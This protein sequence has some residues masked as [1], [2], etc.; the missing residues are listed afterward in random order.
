[1]E[2]SRGQSNTL[3]KVRQED[4]QSQRVRVAGSW[5]RNERHLELWWLR[6][7]LHRVESD[8]ALGLATGGNGCR[9]SVDKLDLDLGN[10]RGASLE[11]GEGDLLGGEK[12]RE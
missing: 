2:I 9:D 11:A 10:G 1:M 12:R 3:T 8:L 5:H 7:R 6:E 4:G